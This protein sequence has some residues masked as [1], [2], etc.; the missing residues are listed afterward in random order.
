MASTWFGE[1][2]LA[3]KRRWITIATTTEVM[4][5][6]QMRK[7]SLYLRAVLGWNSKM[8]L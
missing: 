6:V 7:A 1:K 4:K 5:V 3:L 8:K 2:P